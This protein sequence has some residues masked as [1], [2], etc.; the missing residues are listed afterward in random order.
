[1]QRLVAQVVQL[2]SSSG[3]DS[4][5]GLQKLGRAIQAEADLDRLGRLV[6]GRHWWEAS[7]NQRAEYQLLFRDL[8]L[9]KFAGHLGTYAGGDVGAAESAFRILGS[10]QVSEH[11]ILVRS[12]VRPAE[13]E[14]LQVSW[15][16]R[17]RDTSPAIIDV[18]VEGISLLV[19]Q[20]SEFGT[21]IERQGMDGLL[22]E[23]RARLDRTQS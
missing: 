21:V 19:T 17:Q 14:P 15:R 12:E 6:L 23:L 22:S 13:R 16:L 1:M 4:D 11:D 10:Q 8:M 3:I 2:L 18:V 20:R 9:R 7:E 5:E